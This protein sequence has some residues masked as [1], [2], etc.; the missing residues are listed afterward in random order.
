[1]IRNRENH[2]SI[3]IGEAVYHLG[4]YDKDGETGK[5]IEKWVGSDSDFK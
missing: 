3:I 5:Y 2:R 4:G 1:M